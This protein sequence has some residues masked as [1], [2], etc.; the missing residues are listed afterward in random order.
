MQRRSIG[1]EPAR[2]PSLNAVSAFRYSAATRGN[3]ARA[4]SRAA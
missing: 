4:V 3:S 1:E 2:G